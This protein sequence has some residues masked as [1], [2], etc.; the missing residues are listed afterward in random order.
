MN[1]IEMF[2]DKI[3]T[4]I[5]HSYWH[6]KHSV[7][8]IYNITPRSVLWLLQNSFSQVCTLLFQQQL[9]MHTLK[10]ILQHKITSLFKVKMTAKKK[11][12]QNNSAFMNINL[13]L[14]SKL[15]FQTQTIFHCFARKKRKP[16]PPT[17]KQPNPKPNTKHLMLY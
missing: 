7:A 2:K 8:V 3:R 11:I 13:K 14:I 6:I 12:F 10:R 15:M 9:L 1:Q 4:Q 17:M 16:P 5:N